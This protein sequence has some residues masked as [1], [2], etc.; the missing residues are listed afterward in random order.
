MLEEGSW[1]AVEVSRTKARPPDWAARAASSSDVGRE[2]LRWPKQPELGMDGMTTGAAAGED[3]G[4][5]GSNSV[6]NCRPV[7]VGAEEVG[8]PEAR[9]ERG[10]GA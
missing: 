10:G 1:W 4:W 7:V 9:V 2:R 5:D 6:T 3:K 8:S